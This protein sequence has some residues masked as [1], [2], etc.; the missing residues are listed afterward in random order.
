ML[1]HLKRSLINDRYSIIICVITTHYI[2]HHHVYH[3]NKPAYVFYP[4]STKNKLWL[5][6]LHYHSSQSNSIDIISN[7]SLMHLRV[8]SLRLILIGNVKW[9][10]RN[11]ENNLLTIFKVLN[12]LQVLVN[13]TNCHTDINNWLHCWELRTLDYLTCTK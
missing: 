5:F 11:K 9:L 6:A 12:L 4:L 1:V 7:T 8:S 13:K 3:I 2:N 10:H